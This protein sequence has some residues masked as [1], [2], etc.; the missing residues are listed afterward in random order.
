MGYEVAPDGMNAKIMKWEQADT[1]RE[2]FISLYE[3]CKWTY[4]FH[5]AGHH[6]S[7]MLKYKMACAQTVFM[8]GEETK[9]RSEFWYDT[10]KHGKNIFFIK[11]NLSNLWQV[12]WE[13]LSM[14]SE[15]LEA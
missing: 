2:D 13:A 8:V 7:A 15:Q 4:T 3:Q 14:G 10:L 12:L 6:Y 9:L 1:P 11:D 5:V